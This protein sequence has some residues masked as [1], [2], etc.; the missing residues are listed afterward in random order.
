MRFEGRPHSGLV[1]GDDREESQHGAVTPLPPGPVGPHCSLQLLFLFAAARLAP[2]GSCLDSMG[3]PHAVPHSLSSRGRGRLRG[4]LE[5]R[6]LL[7]FSPEA[8]RGSQGASRAATGTA[9][10]TG[11]LASQRHPGKFPKVPGRRRGKRGFPA[12]PGERPRESFFNVSRGPSP[13]PCGGLL[14]VAGRLSGT[15]SPFRAEQ[16]TS[17]ET[18]SRARCSGPA[19][20]GLFFD[21][22][23]CVCLLCCDY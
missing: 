9:T 7:G 21:V 12:V 22:V 23:N 20:P 18:P 16:G 14:G 13:L 10:S 17:L 8:R 19:W 5:M 11:S 15:V 6:R 1:V 2:G 3:S 4:F